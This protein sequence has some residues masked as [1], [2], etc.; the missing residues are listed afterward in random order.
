GIRD[1]H[2]TGVQTC[3]LPI[4]WTMTLP[5][6][7]LAV[8]SVVGGF[9]G[10]PAL[11]HE[12]L[13]FLPESWIHHWLGADYGGPVAEPHYERHVPHA[14]EWMLL[15]LGAAIAV[16]GVVIAWTQWGRRGPDA[17]RGPR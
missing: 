9:F 7:V 3:A 16:A 6:V 17:D 11:L 1:F 14:T 5:L 4:S 15:G 10:V 13:P 8:L 2:V 12:A